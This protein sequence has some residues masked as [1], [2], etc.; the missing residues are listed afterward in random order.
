MHTKTSVIREIYSLRH[1]IYRCDARGVKARIQFMC[2]A[3]KH[4][5]VDEINDGSLW[6]IGYAGLGSRQLD[7][8]FEMGDADEIGMAVLKAAREEGFVPA[9]Q[10]VFSESSLKHWGDML[11]T[12]LA[13]F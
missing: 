12:Q 1:S 13:L 6:D 7:T 8:C 2:L 5:L 4:D 10:G 9:M 11:D 3:L